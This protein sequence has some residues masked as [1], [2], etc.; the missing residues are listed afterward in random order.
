MEGGELVQLAIEELAR[1]QPS[2]LN[3]LNKK[4]GI[5]RKHT[6][7]DLTSPAAVTITTQVLPLKCLKTEPLIDRDLTELLSSSR[8]PIRAG[9]SFGKYCTEERKALEEKGNKID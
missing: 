6:H 2:L 9:K 8:Q 5:E 3:Q 7:E 4:M 1:K